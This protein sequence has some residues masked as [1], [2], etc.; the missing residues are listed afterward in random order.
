M[1]TQQSAAKVDLLDLALCLPIILRDL[2]TVL[3]VGIGHRSDIYMSI[4]AGG[5][6]RNHRQ[7]HRDS[8]WYVLPFVF[9]FVFLSLLQHGG[10]EAHVKIL[11]LGNH[12][13]HI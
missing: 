1:Q 12:R 6:S 7:A 10:P 9:P 5:G 11:I 2:S 8:V 4:Q 3:V 13:K